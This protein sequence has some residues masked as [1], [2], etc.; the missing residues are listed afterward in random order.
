MVQQNNAGTKVE[1]AKENSAYDLPK[2]CRHQE[3][4]TPAYAAL[5]NR[6]SMQSRMS[7]ILM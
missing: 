3:V 7:V 6:K 2:S 5:E 1:H 4:T